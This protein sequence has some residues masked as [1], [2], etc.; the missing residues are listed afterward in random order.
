MKSYCKNWK[1]KEVNYR[2]QVR[3]LHYISKKKFISTVKELILAISV[4]DNGE[5]KDK[6]LD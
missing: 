6:V 2:L 5:H 1:I 4:I 3:N